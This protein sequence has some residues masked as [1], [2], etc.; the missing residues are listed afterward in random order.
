MTPLAPPPQQYVLL[1]T[2][3]PQLCTQPAATDV[4]LRSPLT[5]TGVLLHGRP[6][7]ASAA[8]SDPSW[9][10]SLPPQ[11]NAAPSLAIAHVW[12]KPAATCAYALDP[13]ASTGVVV[14]LAVS[15]SVGADA[16]A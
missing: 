4:N 8:A 3:M 2:L 5:G 11:Q 1:S 15:V 10:Y 16:H 9:L 7:Q 6:P 12:T 13:P 14:R